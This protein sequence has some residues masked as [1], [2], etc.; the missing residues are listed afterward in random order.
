MVDSLRPDDHRTKTMAGHVHAL[1]E[2]APRI[3]VLFVDSH[4]DGLDGGYV[5]YKCYL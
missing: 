1:L 2:G 5:L 4:K 3:S